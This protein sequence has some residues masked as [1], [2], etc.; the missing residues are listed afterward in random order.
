MLK[1]NYDKRSGG[2]ARCKHYIDIFIIHKQHTNIVGQDEFD[3]KYEMYG[4]N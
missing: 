4:I 2:T 3:G 1:R